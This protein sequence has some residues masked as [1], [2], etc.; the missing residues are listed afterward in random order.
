M[1]VKPLPPQPNLE[2]LR[3]E[4]RD[5]LRAQMAREAQAAQRLR[6][7]DLRFRHASDEEIFEARLKASDAQDAIARERGF[8]NWARLKRWV[9]RPRRTDDLTLPAHE[10]IEDRA[11]REAVDWLDA[12]ETDK[13]RRHLQNHPEVARQRVLL[14]GGNYFQ[15]P[16]LLE[17]IAENPIRRGKLPANIGDVARVILEAGAKDDP[18]ALNGALGLVCSGRVPRE[19]GVQ[20]A[21][22]D[23][24][25]EYGASADSAIA[26]ALPHGEFAA[27]EALLRQGAKL[28]VVVAAGL[29]RVDTVQGMLGRA[30]AA[31]RHKALAMAAQFGRTGIVR[32]L[33]EA[34]E[35]LSRYNPIGM[36]A[37]STPLH[38]TV[39]G[40]H[41]DTVRLLVELR[42]RL[43]VRDTMWQGTP[44]DWAE[45]L[46]K[47]EIAEHLR[48]AR[49]R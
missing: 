2:D 5:L 9:E 16:S 33:A 26:A 31:E 38:Q 42:A 43:D 36:H 29:G 24:L 45:Y 28:D 44:Q 49:E 32:M 41:V 48:R 27:V 21:L 12:G 35:Q 19:C 17:F 34:G 4:A 25:S 40:G 23:L 39:A 30:S 11:F 6:E 8:A 3:K 10:R 37:H 20:I 14:E 7:F 1:P 47:T 15:N 46:G 22:I 18:A 13:L